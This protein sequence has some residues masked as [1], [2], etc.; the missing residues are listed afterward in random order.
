MAK[1]KSVS[2][3]RAKSTWFPP[4]NLSHAP[5]VEDKDYPA[6]HPVVKR[7][8]EAFEEIRIVTHE[9][10]PVERATAAPGEKRN[11]AAKKSD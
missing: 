6:D 1:S 7:Y 2:R 3:F 10:A 5:I 9:A 8:P 11:T 4:E